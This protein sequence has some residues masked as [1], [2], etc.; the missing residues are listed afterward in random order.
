MLN[1]FEIDYEI[2]SVYDYDGDFPLLC[3]ALLFDL[4][5][6]KGNIIIKN[7]N[8]VKSEKAHI[9]QYYTINKN[10]YYY[11]WPDSPDGNYCVWIRESFSSN[12]ELMD[13]LRLQG[14]YLSYIV[15]TESFD[16]KSFTDNWQKDDTYLLSSNQ[17]SFICCVIDADRD[18]NLNFNASI[19]SEEKI[20]YLLTKWEG[21]IARVAS[22]CRIERT[23]KHM[24]SKNGTKYLVQLSIS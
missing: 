15:P 14:I 7:R 3:A 16:W 22:S 1:G 10:N 6:I 17:A 13:L 4:L 18:L 2:E 19:F 23:V 5:N 21:E 9:M 12:R 11:E 8:T 24:R 20:T